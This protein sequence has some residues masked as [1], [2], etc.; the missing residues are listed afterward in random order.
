MTIKGATKSAVESLCRTM[1]LELSPKGIRINAV[2]PTVV[3]TEM[4][5]KVWSD[6]VKA[7]PMLKRIP[8]GRFAG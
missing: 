6:P 3:M 8:L 5:K 2:C 7:E 4:G 1:A